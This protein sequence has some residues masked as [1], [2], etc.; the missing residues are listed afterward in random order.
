MIA[1]DSIDM[2]HALAPSPDYTIELPPDIE[3]CSCDESFA[4][5]R[6]LAAACEQLEQFGAAP[7]ICGQIDWRAFCVHCGVGVA[8]DQ[9]GCCASCGGDVCTMDDVDAHLGAVGLRI[10]RGASDHR[11]L[12]LTRAWG[13]GGAGCD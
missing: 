6:E 4:L 1:C 3:I 13:D 7:V 10:E 9:D 11:R 2:L 12:A 8:F 5:R